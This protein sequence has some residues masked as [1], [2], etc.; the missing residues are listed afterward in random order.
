MSSLFSLGLCLLSV[1]PSP[2]THTAPHGGSARPATAQGHEQREQHSTGTDTQLRAQKAH[3]LVGRH[4]VVFSALL[5][6]PGGAYQG[7]AGAASPCRPAATEA[8]LRLEGHPAA[9]TGSS[10]HRRRCLHGAC[11]LSREADV[12][13][14]PSHCDEYPTQVHAHR[15]GRGGL[16]RWT[17][18][19]L[20]RPPPE[21]GTT[22]CVDLA[23][24]APRTR[25]AG[26]THAAR[27]PVGASACTCCCDPGASVSDSH[28]SSLRRSWRQHS[29][30]SPAPATP[31]APRCMRPAQ[32]RGAGGGSQRQPPSAG[33]SPRCPGT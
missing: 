26:H 19:A 4:P 22:C 23:H 18:A 8:Q 29:R 27:V 1:S 7:R 14:W 11:V 25:P 15:E 20:D 33:P 28:T 24:A 17:G 31:A 30:P 10:R 21:R 12:W 16:P 32:R 9:H 2:P 6:P 3:L 5:P 13:C